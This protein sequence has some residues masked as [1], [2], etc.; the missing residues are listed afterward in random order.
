[1]NSNI[2]NR[3]EKKW[4]ILINERK[5]RD[6][7]NPYLG[8]IASPQ[9]DYA[10]K[11]S[12]LQKDSFSFTIGKQIQWLRDNGSVATLTDKFTNDTTQKWHCNP[13]KARPPNLR[14]WKGKKKKIK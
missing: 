2:N 11:R 5:R 6:K 10:T 12:F 1:M 7:H 8:T 13:P 4:N 9:K 3:S 14:P